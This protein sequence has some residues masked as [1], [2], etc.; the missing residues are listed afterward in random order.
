MR[1]V[2]NEQ[3]TVIARHDFMPFGEELNP[4]TSSKDRKLFTGQ[5]RDFET[6]LDY[7]NARQY[8]P[9]LGQF[10]APDP[11]SL[12]PEPVGSQALGSYTY[13]S[14]RPMDSVDP[15]GMFGIS[16][17][18]WTWGFGW[19]SGWFSFMSGMFGGGAGGTGGGLSMGS[20]VAFSLVGSSRAL[21]EQLAM[22]SSLY[23]SSTAKRRAND[24]IHRRRKRRDNQSTAGRTHT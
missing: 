14:N 18:G 2:T 24:S 4:P 7:F 5:E 8:R 13:V 15:S 19:V 3:R 23:S 22:L 10:T 1:A 11:M 20:G 17:G 21:D 9:D 12:A 16:S 6:G